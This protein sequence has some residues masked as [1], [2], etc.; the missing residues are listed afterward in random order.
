MPDAP[1]LATTGSPTT[2]PD[3]LAH[4]AGGV[5]GWFGDYLRDPG[6][7]VAHLADVLRELVI[8]WGPVAGPVLAAILGVL[9]V[10]G[11]W[12]RAAL[13]RP[14]WWPTP[15]WSPCSPPRGRP[16]GRAGVVGATWSGCCAPP[17]GACWPGSRTSPA[18]TCSPTPGSTMRLWVPGVIPPGLV[19]RAIE[20]AWPGAHTHTTPAQAPLPT[21]RPRAPPAGPGRASCA[22]PA[23]KR[24][25]SAPPST[26]TRSAPCSAPRPA[27]AGR[28]RLRADPGPPGHRPPAG[29][30]P[31]AR[32]A[33]S[34]PA[35]STR[36][37]GQVLDLITPGAHSRRRT[38]GHGREC[39]I[40]RPRWSTP[41]PDR[42]IVAKQ[43]GAQYETLI[44]Y[45]V[46]TTLPPT[47]TAASSG[48]GRATSRGAGRTPWPPRSPPT[49]STTTT[50]A[51]GCATPPAP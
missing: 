16:G 30:G 38:G 23:P 45:A 31:A 27:W 17:G 33:A 46:A 6:A 26:P 32:R 12:W 50:P 40:R 14:S 15:G 13:P 42:A 7:T 21:L 20:A 11:R 4:P 5:G 37:V 43:R 2:S 9:A 47:P 51:A 10:G 34:T 44:R 35:R 29:A 24:C 36:L 8:A 49:P 19:E 3:G 18:S 25:R 39:W 28:A 22:W 48:A 41:R 1:S